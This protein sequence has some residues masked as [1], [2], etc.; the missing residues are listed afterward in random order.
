MKF[1]SSLSLHVSCGPAANGPENEPYDA[2]SVGCQGSHLSGELSS[3]YLLLQTL[4]LVLLDSI[5]LGKN[6]F[7]C[8]AACFNNVLILN[9]LPRYAKS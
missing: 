3:G 5:H 4:S 8:E 2:A 1:S 7:T 6:G 9:Q